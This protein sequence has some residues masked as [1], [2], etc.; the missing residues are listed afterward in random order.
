M[1][2]KFWF[3]WVEGTD[4]VCPK[5]YLGFGEAYEEAQR[6]AKSPD[7][8]GKKVYVLESICYSELTL[9]S[10]HLPVG[11]ASFTAAT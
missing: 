10:I 2:D 5:K 7:S 4:D 6:L 1:V 9:I 8:Q 3:C 11:G